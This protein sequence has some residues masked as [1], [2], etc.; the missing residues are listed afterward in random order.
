MCTLNTLTWPD[1]TTLFNSY[2]PT[3]SHLRRWWPSSRCVWPPWSAWSA[4]RP[5]W[6]ARARSWPW[7]TAAGRQWTCSAASSGH[8]GS[9]RPPRCPTTGGSDRPCTTRPGCPW[10]MT[11]GGGRS[12]ATTGPDCCGTCCRCGRHSGRGTRTPGARTLRHRFGSGWRHC[13]IYELQAW[14]L[15]ARGHLNCPVIPSQMMHMTRRSCPSWV[16]PEALSPPCCCSENASPLCHTKPE[17]RCSPRMRR[18]SGCARR[19]WCP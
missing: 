7:R 14:L 17:C 15:P 18:S 12:P 6:P 2:L 4:P 11:G 1:H 8:C 10:T 16:C 3:T 9:G 5:V 19:I 13:R